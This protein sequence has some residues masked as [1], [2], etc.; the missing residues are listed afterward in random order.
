M[1]T[2][3][4]K[5]LILNA[6]KLHYGIE[7][8]ADF[9]RFLDIK[10]QTLSSWHARNTFDIDL[11]YAKCVDVSP[12]FLLSGKG[13]RTRDNPNRITS[14]G[15]TAADIGERFRIIREENHYNR[16][17]FAEILQINNS[18]YSKIELGKLLP[19]LLQCID[20]SQKFAASLDWLIFGKAQPILKVEPEP[21][22]TGVD[23]QQ[24]NKILLENNQLLRNIME[25]KDRL[26]EVDARKSIRSYNEQSADIRT[27]AEESGNPKLK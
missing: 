21:Q 9:A 2:K 3:I 19:T 18:Q 12:D 11:L 17:Q 26:N 16:T 13:P 27:V 6:I 1:S 25:L 23:L 24:F 14:E 5:S 22:Q 8:D 4:D 20:V 15:H 7:K 10:P